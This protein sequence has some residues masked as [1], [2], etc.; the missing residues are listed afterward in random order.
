M[1]INT[2]KSL[3]CKKWVSDYSIY[4]KQKVY[5]QN[6]VPHTYYEFKKDN[7]FLFYSS[8]DSVHGVGIWEYI[9]EKKMIRFGIK[10]K[11]DTVFSLTEDILTTQVKVVEET[12]KIFLVFKS[13]I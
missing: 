5:N 3:L 1:S 8:T 10:G 9:P 6:G 11:Y 7:T 4:G 13:S 12:P 2:V